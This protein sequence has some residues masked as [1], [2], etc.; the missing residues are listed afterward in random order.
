MFLVSDCCM[1]ILWTYS[2]EAIE[3]L[4]PLPCLKQ[5]VFYLMPNLVFKHTSSDANY[6]CPFNSLDYVTCLVGKLLW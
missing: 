3:H 1:L 5:M 6:L 4:E 2:S